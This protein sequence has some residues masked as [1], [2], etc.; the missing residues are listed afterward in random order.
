MSNFIPDGNGGREIVETALDKLA[1][2]ATPSNFRLTEADRDDIVAHLADGPPV[3]TDPETGGKRTIVVMPRI[4]AGGTARLRI[5]VL[6][7][8]LVTA[9]IHATIPMDRGLFVQ[10]GYVTDLVRSIL[11]Q[12]PPSSAIAAH[13][14]TT[15][16]STSTAGIDCS[17]VYADAC[18]QM[19]RTETG[20][21]EA[22]R[23]GQAHACTSYSSVTFGTVGADC[24]VDPTGPVKAAAKKKFPLL[25]WLDGIINA[26]DLYGDLSDSADRIEA[27]GTPTQ[28]GVQAVDPNDKLSPA[29]YGADHWITGDDPITY[30]IRFENVRTATAAAQQVELTDVLPPS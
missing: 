11:A 17:G 18:A 3:E 27:A 1:S 24:Q 5:G 12:A 22:R 30:T 15:S 21:D 20:I 6:P 4:P 10:S 9:P 23:I 2:D 7:R 14:A 19:Y 25:S 13:S 26:F 29:G 8:V 16:A 28:F